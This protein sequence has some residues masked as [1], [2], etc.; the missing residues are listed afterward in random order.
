MLLE[1]DRPLYLCLTASIFLFSACGGG[2]GG[3]GRPSVD[4]VAGDFTPGDTAFE[5]D[6]LG[7]ASPPMMPDTAQVNTQIV[8]GA[9]ALFSVTNVGDAPTTVPI[10]VSLH[11][12][13]FQTL[14][15]DRVIPVKDNRLYDYFTIAEGF[16][17]GAR[18]DASVA[19]VLD[20]ANV[21]LMGFRDVP[22]VLREGDYTLNFFVDSAGALDEADETNNRVFDTNGPRNFDPR[23]DGFDVLSSEVMTTSNAGVITPGVT[24]TATISVAN[25]GDADADLVPIA[26]FLARP[27]GGLVLVGANDG[28]SIAAGAQ[29]LIT[30]NCTFPT[31]AA[32]GPGDGQIIAAVGFDP[33]SGNFITGD[34]ATANNVS[35]DHVRFTN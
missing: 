24:F 22:V 17:P 21:P 19:M 32:V 35:R 23:E 34:L 9:N 33:A 5:G 27:G 30:L 28:F 1:T 13:P 6:R 4:L 29:D 8:A 25:V 11:S 7:N 2:G 10:L 16:G 20:G 31:A 14:K 3:N 15:P 26:V 12:A 18:M